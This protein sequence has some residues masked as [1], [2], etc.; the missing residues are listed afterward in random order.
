M[1]ISSQERR[2]KVQR[3]RPTQRLPMLSRRSPYVRRRRL[4]RRRQG[5]VPSRQIQ[6]L[7]LRSPRVRPAGARARRAVSRSPQL[8]HAAEAGQGVAGQ[9]LGRRQEQDARIQE[10]GY[11][12]VLFV[13]VSFLQSQCPERRTIT[14]MIAVL[15]HDRFAN[16]RNT[17]S[18]VITMQPCG[19]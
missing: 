1:L 17:A 16:Q 5:Q 10:G 19:M 12:P 3:Q 11:G 6:R 15:R 9:N 4:Q 14:D 2:F 8:G 13:W 18:A 7:W